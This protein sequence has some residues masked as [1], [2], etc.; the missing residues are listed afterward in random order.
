VIFADKSFDCRININGDL[1]EP[2]PLLIRP[3]TSEFFY[4][5]DR[6]GVI[7]MKKNQQ[8]ELHCTNGFSSPLGI[9]RT[10]SISCEGGK[11]FRLNGRLYNFN[12]FTCRNFPL[13]SARRRPFSRCYA[14]GIYVDIGFQVEARF[15][16]VMT[17]CHNPSTEQTYYTKYKLTPANEG[18]QRAFPRPSFIQSDFFPG[19]N[20][21]NL[22]TRTTQRETIATTLDSSAMAYK[23]VPQTS[24][25]F[26]ARGNFLCS[27]YI[28]ITL[29]KMDN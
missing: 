12:E 10:V 9:V 26:L 11:Q 17:V 2:Q 6:S 13:H 5:N 24:D 7:K 29:H 8:I 16:L 25:A 20:I 21:N 4:P 14:N 23:F 27:Q 18:I 3:K 22:Y 19:K 1:G 28:L 15:L